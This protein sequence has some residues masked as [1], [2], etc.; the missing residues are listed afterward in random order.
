MYPFIVR[1]ERFKSGGTVPPVPGTCPL[2]DETDSV[3]IDAAGDVILLRDPN[4]SIAVILCP[5]MVPRDV[6]PPV[7][8][9]PASI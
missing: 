1:V 5:E 7:V 2:M 9:S 8:I 3:E 6:K 4:C